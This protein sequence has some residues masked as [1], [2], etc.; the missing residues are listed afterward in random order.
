MSGFPFDAVLWDI[1]G[2]LA[3]SE[4][5]HER[6]FV[7][8][9]ERLGLDLPPDFHGHIIGRSDEATHG[10]LT[11]ACGLDLP[12]V[13][14]LERRFAAY[15]DDLDSVAPFPEAVALWRRLDALGVKQAAVSNSDRMIVQANL[16]RI[17]LMR[18]GLVSVARNDVRAGKPAAE[19]YRRA[20][21]LLGVDA[22]ACA[23]VEDSATGL[24]SAHAAGAS[25]FV[26]PW[27]G[28][29][30]DGRWRGFESLCA[31]A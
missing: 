3:D 26:M 29:A 17:G 15:L 16:Q 7:T 27:F 10:W 1:D 2:T 22:G 6:S 20:A 14:W 28:G 5:T 21:A 19:P 30:A 4:P 11:E 24:E 12:L 13:D 18:P 25:V 31:M 9:C 8:A 23:A